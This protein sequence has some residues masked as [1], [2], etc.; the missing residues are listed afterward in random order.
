M[1]RTAITS[2]RRHGSQKWEQLAGQH[3]PIQEQL[4]EFRRLRAL[5]AHPAF[6]EAEYWE[7]DGGCRSNTKFADPA[8][9]QAAQSADITDPVSSEA[10]PEATPPGDGEL[11]AEAPA[12]QTPEAVLPPTPGSPSAA[13]AAK[14]KRAR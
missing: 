5:P 3:V 1:P 11:T 10:P 4:V 14:P 7:R 6:A 9:K 12:N 8:A 2:I 13:A